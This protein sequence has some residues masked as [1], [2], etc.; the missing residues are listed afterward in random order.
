MGGS[1]ETPS[2]AATNFTISSDASVIASFTQGPEAP[3]AD[4]TFAPIEP[5]PG[6]QVSFV[7]T[8]SGLPTSWSW[9][10]EDDGTTDAT[11]QNVTHAFSSAGPHSVSLRVRNAYGEDRETR[12]V[13]V[14]SPPGRPKIMKVTWEYPGVFLKGATIANRLDVQVDWQGSPG[15]VLFAVNG[16]A[17]VSEPGGTAGAAHTFRLATDFPARWES[18]TVSITAVNSVGGRSE[19]V[20]TPMSVFPFPAWLEEA[21]HFKYG[22]I[23]FMAGAGEVKATATAEFPK[24]HLAQAGPIDIPRWIPYLGGRFGLLETFVR[25]DGTVSSNGTGNLTLYGQTGFTAM[26]QSLRGDFSGAGEFRLF[27]PKGLELVHATFTLNLEGTL[28]RQVGLLEAIPALAAAA[29]RKPLSALN[30]SVTLLGELSPSL[31]LTAA[32]GQDPRDGALR[33]SEATGTGRLAFKATLETGI[34]VLGLRASLSAWLGGEGTIRLGV[35]DPLM[36]A[37]EVGFEVGAKASF[38]HLLGAGPWV[39]KAGCRWEHGETISCSRADTSARMAATSDPQ[40]DLAFNDTPLETIQPSYELHGEYSRLEQSPVVKPQEA[41]SEIPVS[42]TEA[43]LVRN[44]FP[45]AS[46]HLAAV[47]NGQLL[48]WE[49]QNRDLPTLQSTDIAWTLRSGASWTSVELIGQDS[50]V[51]LSPVAAVDRGGKVVAAWLRVKETAFSDYVAFIGDLPKFYKQFEVVSATF[52]PL[53][54]RWSQITALTNDEVFDTDLRLSWGGNG[55]LMLSWLSNPAGELVSTDASPSSLRYAF[56]DGFGW[57]QVGTIS[58]SLVGV[59]S[60][61]A[62][63]RGNRAFV[64]FSYASQ[65]ESANGAL[66]VVAW[67]GRAWGARQTLATADLDNRLPAAVYDGQGEG[68]VVWLRGTDLVHATLSQRTP[69]V[70]RPGSR[71]VAFYGAHLAGNDR[72]DMALVWAE[73]ADNSPANLFALLFDS[74]SRTWSAD[75]RLNLDPMK[76]RDFQGYLGADGAIHGV[77]LATEINRVDETVDVGGTRVTIPNIPQDGRT[78]LRLLDHSLVPDLAV[79][80]KDLKVSPSRPMEGQTISATLTVHN[81]GDYPMPTFVVDLRAGVPPNGP[82]L[83]DP[84]VVQGPFPAGATR[85][86]TFTLTYPDGGG[87]LFAVVDPQNAVAEYTKANNIAVTRLTNVAP[88]AAVAADVTA[89]VAPLAVTFDASNSSDPDGDG[90]TYAWAFGDGSETATGIRISHT[91][92]EPG[93]YSVVVSAMD[94]MGAVGTAAVTITVGGGC[95]AE[96]PPVADFDWEPRGPLPAHPQQ[97]Q[98]FVGQVVRM[99]DRSSREPSGWSWYDFQSSGVAYHN[100]NPTHVWDSAGV[101]NVRLT[102]WNCAGLSREALKSVTVYPDVRPP[103]AFPLRLDFGTESSPVAAGFLRVTATTVFGQTYRYGWLAGAVTARDR[104]GASALNRDFVFTERATFGV[105]LA[106]GTYDIAL[107][108]GDALYSHDQMG[109]FLEG[110]QVDSVDTRAGEYLTRRYRNV[111]VGDGELTLHV[112]DLGGLDRTVVINGLEVSPAVPSRFDFGTASSPV[113]PGY[114][115]VLPAMAYDPQRGFGWL[116]GRIDGRDRGS[117]DPLTRDFNYTTAGVFV[118]DLANGTYDITVTLGDWSYHHDEIEITIEGSAR[119][120]VTTTARKFLTRTFEVEVS[121]GQ[122]TLTLSDL[123]GRD[124]HAV[125]N[126]L[127]IRSTTP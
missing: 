12:T 94:T 40:G 10:F 108:M 35:P 123:G 49:Q 61:T 46:P 64:T 47:G 5:Q 44:L 88:V 68:H 76:A 59:G 112:D 6:Q 19:S 90:L 39:F 98:P 50:R 114:A 122:L 60:H 70:V 24:P 34:R 96:G 74:S 42:S 48:L 54:R 23:T 105:E 14:G 77:Y 113:S 97:L 99:L 107:M 85:N 103:L 86:V 120:T 72:G 52:D 3:R 109:V 29:R 37:A 100:Q 22:N 36:R 110:L 62:A 16:A 117:S 106:E 115:Q 92:A 41:S 111:A 83:V 71:S 121:D 82:S 51:E 87:E 30:S 57:G 81:A 78:D 80:D 1:F 65:L 63:R 79:S 32:F 7:D 127:E 28:K 89:G 13:Q 102:S 27:R 101:K 118:A 38:D 69:V 4:F 95:A 91:F 124:P 45:G 126:A 26:E 21:V 66:D 67:D 75:R 15:A 9:D 33:F 119:D 20:S 116:S 25:I 104:G 53:T 93:E 56:W 18:S 58:S 2:A 17:P 55:D 11:S 43:T 73:S 31:E 84:A 125:I 8:S